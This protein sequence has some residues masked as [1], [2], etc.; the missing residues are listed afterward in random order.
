MLQIYG[1]KLFSGIFSPPLTFMLIFLIC[2][3]LSS[4][5]ALA[6][7]PS[8]SNIMSLIDEKLSKWSSIQYSMDIDLGGADFGYKVHYRSPSTLRTVSWNKNDNS[9]KVTMMVFKN[10]TT[11][12][13][14]K[15]KNKQT[16]DTGSFDLFR[17]N[18]EYDKNWKLEYLG[19]YKL[20]YAKDGEEE[21]R[22]CWVIQFT[23]QQGVQYRFWIDK[24]IGIALRMEVRL[25]KGEK[26]YV[27]AKTKS[28]KLDVPI[29]DSV[30]K[31]P[32]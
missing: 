13:D 10:T 12:F 15:Q 28:F 32:F 25:K 22:G 27:I 5:D 18:N 24:Y 31:D 29:E 2:C 19:D 23:T 21:D 16:H 26:P 20:S 8:S 1:R 17:I 14:H 9:D 6:D 4:S 30:F 11:I 7:E 3:T